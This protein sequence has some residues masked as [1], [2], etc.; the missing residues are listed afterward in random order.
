MKYYL[1]FIG[2]LLWTCTLVSQNVRTQQ[3]Y[4]AE[5]YLGTGISNQHIT[6]SEASLSAAGILSS[7]GSKALVLPHFGIDFNRNLLKDFDLGIGLRYQNKGGR[8]YN[9]PDLGSETSRYDVS[10]MALLVF[11]TEYRF[12]KSLAICNAL[13]V[14]N[15]IFRGTRPSIV[16]WGFISGLKLNLGSRFSAGVFYNQSLNRISLFPTFYDRKFYSFDISLFY[17]IRG[18]RIW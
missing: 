6:P 14:G 17:R 18:I 3:I 1:L 7:M 8:Y 16:E 9:K 12:Y 13:S 11:K 5:L 2:L 15:N 4:S 10:S